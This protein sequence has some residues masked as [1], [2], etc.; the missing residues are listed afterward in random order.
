MTLK[1]ES[2]CRK[3]LAVTRE[4]ESMD[5]DL[6]LPP[7]ENSSSSKRAKEQGTGEIYSEIVFLRIRLTQIVGW[8]V[9]VSHSISNRKLT[10]SP[11]EFTPLTP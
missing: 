11:R 6:C 5:I 4:E 2:T 9:L 3:V 7:D 10:Y 1:P 8:F